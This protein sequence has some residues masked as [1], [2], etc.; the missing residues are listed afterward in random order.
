MP[1]THGL[2]R[3]LHSFAAS[4]LVLDLIQLLSV[5]LVCIEMSLAFAGGGARATLLLSRLRG[6]NV[7]ARL[8]GVLGMFST[9]RL[10]SFIVLADSGDRGDD[11]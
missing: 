1:R 2:R 4:R 7:T 5:W 9:L 8:G 10:S 6:F 3:G 11:S